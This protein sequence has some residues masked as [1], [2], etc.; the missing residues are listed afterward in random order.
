VRPVNGGGNEKTA[1]ACAVGLAIVSFYLVYTQYYNR[2]PSSLSIA[3]KANITAQTIDD[4]RSLFRAVDENGKTVCSAGF[5]RGGQTYRNLNPRI[6]EVYCRPDS[7]QTKIVDL[8]KPTSDSWRP[9]LVVLDNKIVDLTSSTAWDGKRWTRADMASSENA[10]PLADGLLEF[11][12][13]TE[14]E[15]PT[16]S[17]KNE[18]VIQFPGYTLSSGTY[19]RGKLY[20]ALAP[21]GG[22]EHSILAVCAW[23]LGQSCNPTTFALPD[24]NRMV[25]SM[26]GYDGQIL[27]GG[28][29]MLMRF[30]GEKAFVLHQNPVFEYYSFLV[31]RNSILVGTFPRGFLYEISPTDWSVK[32]IEAPPNGVDGF[33]N[34]EQF[35]TATLDYLNKIGE[36]YYR[37]AQSL[38]LMGGRVFVGM[39][40]WGDV[41][42]RGHGGEWTSIDLVDPGAK[43]NQLPWPYFEEMQQRIQAMKADPRSAS[44]D[45]WLLDAFWARR[46][47]SLVPSPYGLAAGIGNLSGRAYDPERD[48]FMSKNDIDL[49]GR[50]KLL[51]RPMSVFA[52]VAETGRTTLS[53]TIDRSGIRIAQDKK[54]IADAKMPISDDILDKISSV[55]IGAGVYGKTASSLLTTTRLSYVGD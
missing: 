31:F 21:V 42:E 9:S 26:I 19:Y 24:G 2:T 4:Y 44:N 3:I 14:S 47:H 33:Q 38:A 39:Y 27:I 18:T 32:D 54:T 10:I 51:Q 36:P 46:I 52:Q 49:Y 35:E 45:K 23:G 22:E 7:E 40:P 37:E 50:V 12:H 30:D 6:L 48:T 15:P 13:A 43:R 55:V 34:H 16:V 5:Q 41:W 29:G 1:I 11:R 8:G 28:S 20:V 25:Y 17:Y 53:F